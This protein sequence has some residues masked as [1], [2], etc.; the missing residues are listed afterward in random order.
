MVGPSGVT[1]LEHSYQYNIT[2]KDIRSI[3]TTTIQRTVHPG[4]L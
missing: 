2:Y 3:K 1:I 4:R